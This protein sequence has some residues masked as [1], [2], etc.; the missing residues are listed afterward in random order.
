MESSATSLVSVLIE[1]VLRFGFGQSSRNPKEGLFLFGPVRD[2]SNPVEIRA[3]VVG[4]ARGIGA[5]SAWVERLSRPVSAT[6]GSATSVFFPGFKELFNC[7]WNTTPIVGL[8]LSS[9]EL[10]ASIHRSDRHDAVHATVGLFAN[11]IEKF[12]RE[13]DRKVDIWFIVIPDEIFQLGRPLSKVPF[14]LRVQSSQPMNARLA[15]RLNRE[16]SLFPEDMKAAETYLYQVD[17]HNQLKARLIRSRAI[18]QVI[19]ES[20]LEKETEK[21][22]ARRM[23]DAAAIAWNLSVSSFYKAG[24]RPWRLR[25]IRDGVCY[26]GLVFKK[27]VSGGDDRFA[28]CG[29]QMFLTSGDGMVFKG[30]PGP[31]FSPTL[32]EFHLSREQAAEIG[33]RII[34]AYTSQTGSP[35]KEVFIHGRTRF[36]S[37][38]WEGFESAMPATTAICGVRISKSDEFKLFRDGKMPVV[39]GTYLAES[40]RVGYLWTNGFVPDLATY[41]GW[42]VPNPLRIEVC[43]GEA[44]LSTVVADVFQL[45]K[46]N[47]NACIY[48]D[49]LP[50]TLRFADAI[51][52]ILTAAPSADI[53]EVPLPFRHY[54]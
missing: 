14:S 20:T 51:G 46:L 15:K 47:F 34:T 4:T 32:K 40:V 35:P 43:R 31:W 11:V 7:A 10:T 22:S 28:C 24:G 9:S 41:P 53:P 54:I 21:P 30:T 2:H 8:P 33:T 17:F 13:D 26:V 49:G 39:R 38:E 12:L 5:Y 52:E 3:G 27:D 23:Q 1:P 25:D 48:G 50:V 19:R 18:T 37:N 6:T 36:N 44:V 45:T 29:A 42:E 16:P